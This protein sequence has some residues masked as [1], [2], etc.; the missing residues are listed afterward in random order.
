MDELST[1]FKRY[2][3]YTVLSYSV[4][5]V[6]I[7]LVVYLA[8]TAML[9]TPVSAVYMIATIMLFLIGLNMAS[10]ATK[11]RIYYEIEEDKEWQMMY[12][13]KMKM[14]RE[15]A[16]EYEENMKSNQEVEQ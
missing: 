7:M 8:S 12:L 2:L 14:S 1:N 6:A 9:F 11:Y 5:A 15:A 4:I 13:T 16:K 3:A 10:T